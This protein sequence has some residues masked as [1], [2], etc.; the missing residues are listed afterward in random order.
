[1]LR[2][3]RVKVADIEPLR[4]EFGNEFV[5]RDYD[6][7]AN[8][9]YVRELADSFGDA[10]EPDEPVKLIRN[11]A[12]FAIKAGNSRVRAM[13][14]IGT[15]EC[16]AVIDD[17]D[18]VQGVVETVV[19]TDKKKKYEDMELSRFVQQLAAFGDDEYVGHVASIDADNARRVRKAR[20]MIGVEKAE[21]MSLDRLY[22]IPDFEGDDEAVEKLMKANEQSWFGVAEGLRRE[23]GKRE[24]KAAF[25]ARAAE[26]KITLVDRASVVGKRRFACECRKPADLE[27]DYM[28]ASVKYK[29]I[30]GTICDN[31]S[32]VTLDFYGVPISDEGETAE[33]AEKRRLADE[34]ET[35]ADGID[36]A[37]FNWV[38]ER[39]EE[40]GGQDFPPELANLEKAAVKIAKKQWVIKNIIDDFPMAMGQKG[41]YLAFFIGYHD[42][43]TRL[44]RQARSLASSLNGYGITYLNKALDWVELHES[45]GW[46][47]DEGQAAFLEMAREKVAEASKE[48]EEDGK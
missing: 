43:R 21:Q 22:V 11:G 24:L 45:D 39:F 16:W 46:V 30:V 18:T 8:R 12:K 44:A 4:D 5:S 3:E 35:V 1:M 38:T 47:P 31:W 20:E 2:L 34:Y 26:L 6:L 40:A 13:Q 28:A 41:S 23:K 29:N 19:R 36:S 9:D 15:D 42:G 7:P 17:D 48:P 37:I 32:G 33:Q 27:A 14:L 25:E 10:G